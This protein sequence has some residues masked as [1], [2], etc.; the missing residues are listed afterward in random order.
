MQEIADLA[1]D[2]DIHLIQNVD[3]LRSRDGGSRIAM[4]YKFSLSA[5]FDRY[6][7]APAL[8]VVEDDLLFSPDFYEYFR[9]VAPILDEDATTFVISAWS[10]NGFK[11]QVKD[12]YA[13]RRTDYFPGMGWMLT[14]RLYKSELEA[15]W[16]RDHWDEWMSSSVINKNREIVFPQIP[17]S[18]YNGTKRAFMSSRWYFRDIAYNTDAAVNWAVDSSSGTLVADRAQAAPI[19]LQADSAVYEYRVEQLIQRCKHI[20]H[21]TDIVKYKDEILCL[22]IYFNPLSGREPPDFQPYAEFFHLWHERRRGS[23]RGLHEFYF[24]GNYI[25][26][27]NTYSSRREAT[28]AAEVKD[29]YERLK[30]KATRILEPYTFIKGPLLNLPALKANL[31]EPQKAEQMVNSSELRL[32]ASI[33]EHSVVTKETLYKAAQP[34]MSC[35][36]VC[37]ALNLKCDLNHLQLLNSCETMREQFSCA[38]CSTSMG[39]DHP[40]YVPPEADQQF[41]PDSCFVNAVATHTT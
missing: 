13:L 9:A 23:H 41:G 11:G 26:L 40:I 32:V 1:G 30:P 25:L 12:N 24:E 29:S 28:I 6:P 22:W 4:H 35:D 14:R 37:R 5:A 19:Y 18:F 15:Q 3:H 2:N 7:E 33:T 10:D 27:L 34:G 36:Q 38:H 8:I 39:P 17:R 31:K 20:D 16:P 21:V